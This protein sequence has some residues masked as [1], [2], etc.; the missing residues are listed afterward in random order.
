MKPKINIGRVRGGTLLPTYDTL[1]D[2]QMNHHVHVVGPTGYGKTTLLT[3]IFQHQVEAGKGLLFIDLKGDLETIE[4][5]SA[6]TKAAGREADLQLLSLSDLSSTYSYNPFTGDTANQIRDK[7]M[8]AFEW[9]EEFYK[10]QS[11]SFLLKLLI[12]LKRLQVTSQIQC[13][14]ALVRGC[15]THGDKISEYIRKLAK[16]EI[17]ARQCLEE[18]YQLMSSND[19]YKSLQGMRTQVES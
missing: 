1:T 9:S 10:S 15:T 3:H 17:Q 12:G 16:E 7:I 14:P 19:G 4:S 13:T 11:A 6:I 8:S 5:L 18:A 2:E